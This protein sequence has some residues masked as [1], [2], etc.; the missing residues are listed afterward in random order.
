MLRTAACFALFAV[1]ASAIACDTLQAKF[2]NEK[3]STVLSVL[4]TEAGLTL[5]NPQLAD[6]VIDA[7]F[8]N[9][10]A[11]R[12]LRVLAWDRGFELKVRGAEAWLVP[13]QREATA[14]VDAG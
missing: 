4:A 10:E 12:L 2:E 7:T 14:V 5:K 6:G 9:E 11:H 3:A 1:S 13:A 8:E